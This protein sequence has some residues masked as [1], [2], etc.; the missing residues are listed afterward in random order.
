MSKPL[1]VAFLPHLNEL[2]G[3]PMTHFEL[4]KRL[5][6]RRDEFDVLFVTPSAGPLDRPCEKAG[7]KQTVVEN[8]P[9]GIAE[10]KGLFGKVSHLFQK[11]EAKNRLS[12]YFAANPVDVIY[13][14]SVVNVLPAIAAQE[15]KIPLA[16]HLQE[17]PGIFPD[18]VVNRQKAKTIRD[19]ASVIFHVPG[20]ARTL[21]GDLGDDPAQGKPG[22]PAG[23]EVHNSADVARI[24][25]FDKKGCREDLNAEFSI[26]KYGKIV[27]TVATVTQGKGI[28]LLWEAAHDLFFRH[29]DLYFVIVGPDAP[30]DDFGAKLRAE[31]EASDFASRFQFAGR[32]PDVAPYLRGADIFC[33]PT[34][35]EAQPLSIIEAMAAGLPIVTTD[36]GD[37]PRMLKEGEIA[38]LHP[39]GDPQPIQE[40]IE[41]ILEVADVRERYTKGVVERAKDFDYNH[42]ADIVAGALLKMAKRV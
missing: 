10:K 28:R 15:N 21:F 34:L 35:Y 36:V 32:K 29:K 8:P 40:G 38:F 24:Q 39:A 5:N 19:A 22:A 7:L 11:R 26:D 16:Y 33:L 25:T 4:A 30:G 20:A 37:I 14:S 1:K 12:E 41:K 42:A 2:T 9:G 3:A 13:A 6:E 18:N 23:V 27:V 17:S 31:V